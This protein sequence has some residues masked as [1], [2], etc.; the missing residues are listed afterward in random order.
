[1]G[2]E[3]GTR[4][5]V[6]RKVEEKQRLVEGFLTRYAARV[7]TSP[8]AGILVAAMVKA[9]EVVKPG[10][11]V[12][13]FVPLK[14][15]AEFELSAEAGSALRQAQTVQLATGAGREFQSRI[16]VAAPRG[17][18]VKVLVT[19][20][21]GDGVKEGDP[22]RLV[23]AKFENVVRVPLGAI[24]RRPGGEVVYVVTPDA[25]GSV[26]RAR[27]VVVVDR[28]GQDALVSQGLG[29]GDRLVQSGVEA[30]ADGQRVR[31]VH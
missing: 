18:G 26:A 22:V 5:L 6:E 10:Q 17:A 2:A 24:T 14:L 11:P 25:T 7:V 1:G 19:A 20:D 9:G 15:R 23:R 28:D 30:L 3:K 4:R 16:E 29:P 21:P 8:T 12:V 31:P 13:K 27:P